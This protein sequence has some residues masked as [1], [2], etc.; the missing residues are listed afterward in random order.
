MMAKRVLVTGGAGFIGSHVADLLLSR[1]YTVRL[2]DNLSPQVHRNGS[3]PEYL[4]SDA[5]LVIGDVRDETAVERA[6][7]GVDKV[8]HLA[9][10]VGVGQSMYEIASYTEINE[11]GTAILLQA[12]SRRPVERLVCASSMSIYGEGLARRQ[13]GQIV[14]PP[15]RPIEQLR[16]ANWELLDEEGAALTPVPTPE[17]KQP[18]LGSVYALNK[19]SQERLCLIAGKAYNIPT[20][21][22]RFFNVYGPRQALSNP[23]TGVLAIFASRL[24]NGRPPLV[25]EDGLQQRDF[26]HV[27]DVAAACLLAL[28]TGNALN[29]AFNIGSGQ[30]RTIVSIAEELARI[31]RRNDITPHVVGKYRAGDIRHCF[32]DIACSGAALG[33]A[34]RIEF[35]VGLEELAD[36]LCGQVAEDRLDHATAELEQ[37]GLVA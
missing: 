10:A 9:A 29:Q 21:A 36:W 4:N 24:L 23:Y 37:R 28:E 19:Y 1:G 34:P 5:E 13:N 3:S 8:I 32:A 22:L 18:T 27:R 7:Q 20:V 26:V 17:S 14:S 2:L 35:H 31:M 25:F 11:L 16:R 6:L 15:E 12:L 33:F 30:S